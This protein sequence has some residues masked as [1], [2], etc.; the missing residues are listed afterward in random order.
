MKFTTKILILMVY[1]FKPYLALVPKWLLYIYIYFPSIRHHNHFL[2]TPLIGP[3]WELT[4]YP[5]A[6]PCSIWVPNSS[7]A[8][9]LTH[10]SCNGS[11]G[12]WSAGF[13]GSSMLT[14]F[15]SFT[16]LLTLSLP[17]PSH[18][19]VSASPLQQKLWNM[20]PLDLGTAVFT[21]LRQ[22]C[23]GEFSPS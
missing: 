19:S 4:P 1:S 6:V 8:R 13:L 17:F 3:C 22:A 14:W 5:F 7:P 11:M 9:S 12:S 2:N 20:T 18:H 21:V 15:S 23:S 16:S 10:A